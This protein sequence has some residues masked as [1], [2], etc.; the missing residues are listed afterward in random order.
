MYASIYVRGMR[1]AFGA[2]RNES[3]SAGSPPGSLSSSLNR[4]ARLHRSSL[5]AS[6]GVRFSECG[7]GAFPGGGASSLTGWRPCTSQP[8]VVATHNGIGQSE[9]AT[10]RVSA[11]PQPYVV[12]SGS[13]QDDR[14]GSPD[15]RFGANVRALREEKGMSQAALATAMTERGYPWHQQTVGR[16]E[17]GRQSVRFGEIEQLAEIL[18]TS[19]DRF[20]WTQPEAGATQYMYSAGT[21]VVREAE[22][23]S[24]CVFRLLLDLDGADRALTRRR[25]ANTR[26]SRRRE[27]TRP[28]GSRCTTWTRP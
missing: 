18:R 23:V 13:M 5:I 25:T 20:R 7:F 17:G 2:R 11:Q 27:W 21:R 22:K 3:I 15:E 16:V 1:R 8:D 14:R 24:E 12:V 9:N 19:V 26:A 10:R 6:S 28:S 4:V